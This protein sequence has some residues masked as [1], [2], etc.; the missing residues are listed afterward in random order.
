[1]LFNRINHLFDQLN[2]TIDAEAAHK[3]SE[4][5]LPSSYDNYSLAAMINEMN[6]IDN[7]TSNRSGNVV[8]NISELFANDGGLNFTVSPILNHN[9]TTS[10]KSAQFAPEPLFVLILVTICYLFIFIAGIL[11][12]VI[13]CT[14]ISR[15][16]SMHTA[17]NYY[18]FNLAI[19]DLLLLLSG[20][21][22]KID[23]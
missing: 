10:V 22:I 3:W 11:G 2:I 18:L 15:N 20:K 1:M 17:T 19:S 14:V 4:F 16:K 8:F 23:K 9:S 5:D 21:F 13:T 6:S 12:N 7:V